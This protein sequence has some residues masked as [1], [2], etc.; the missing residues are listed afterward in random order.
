MQSEEGVKNEAIRSKE[1]I[2]REVQGE[3]KERVVQRE[4]ERRRAVRLV[5][6]ERE[7][8]ELRKEKFYCR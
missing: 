1:S 8:S 5:E 6:R 2:E 7:R 4:R 3:Y